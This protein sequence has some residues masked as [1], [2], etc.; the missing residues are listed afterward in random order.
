MHSKFG[1]VNFRGRQL[2]QINAFFASS[3]WVTLQLSMVVGLILLVWFCKQGHISVGEVALYQG[4]FSMIVMSVTQM[5][6]L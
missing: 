1:F 6:N 4:M 2:D 3:S 5:L